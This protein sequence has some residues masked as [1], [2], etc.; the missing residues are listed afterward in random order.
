M[1]APKTESSTPGSIAPRIELSVPTTA[2]TK[3]VMPVFGF[4]LGGVPLCMFFQPV[5]GAAA[6]IAWLLGGAVMGGLIYAWTRRIVGA[7]LIGDRLEISDYFKTIQV[8]VEHLVSVQ[9]TWGRKQ[10]ALIL[11]FL[12]PTPFGQT[13]EIIPPGSWWRMPGEIDVEQFLY[14]L[15]AKHHPRPV[16][17]GRPAEAV[18]ALLADA[19]PSQVAELRKLQ[20]EEL[21]VLIDRLPSDSALREIARG[22]R[23]S[24]WQSGYRSGY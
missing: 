10:R 14:D 7:A 8:P 5:G 15:V 19:N 18:L 4:V 21:T 11:T 6:F 2:I 1:T 20:E 3:F 17:D 16:I 12:P 9:S 24:R 13:L 23:Q 22:E